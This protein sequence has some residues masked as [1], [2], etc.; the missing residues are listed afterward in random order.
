MK[1][2]AEGLRTCV[3]L[4]ELNLNN[5]QISDSG[6]EI[7]GSALSSCVKFSYWGEP[8]RAPH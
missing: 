4:W 3:E 1:G 7:L 6:A 8:N 5:N 2:L